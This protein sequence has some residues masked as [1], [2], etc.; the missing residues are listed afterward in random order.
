M[1]RLHLWANDLENYYFLVRTST[2]LRKLVDGFRSEVE[3]SL[4][5]LFFG[6]PDPSRGICG[7]VETML[8]FNKANVDPFT[9]FRKPVEY[10]ARLKKSV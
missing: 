1:V 10:K 7:S 8:D 6:E 9:V 4:P 5:E 3:N 2:D